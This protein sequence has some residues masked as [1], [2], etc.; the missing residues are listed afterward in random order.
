MRRS[1][2][3]D[4]SRGR[5]PAVSSTSGPRAGIDSPVRTRSEVAS[6]RRSAGGPGS[7]PVVIGAGWPTGGIIAVVDALFET[8]CTCWGDRNS[9]LAARETGR[10]DLSRPRGQAASKGENTLPPN[11]QGA[12]GQDLRRYDL[13]LPAVE[14]TEQPHLAVAILIGSIPFEVI[15]R[16]RRRPAPHGGPR[17]RP[18]PMR[19]RVPGP[20]RRAARR[21]GDL[22]RSRRARFPGTPRLR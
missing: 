3:T 17:P 20:G 11:S 15:G 1:R 13:Y 8:R 14:A 9:P 5:R 12:R 2:A 7:T 22:P 19:T 21:A 6:A 4:R 16:V 18:S 10:L